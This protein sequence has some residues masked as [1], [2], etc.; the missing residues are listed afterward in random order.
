MIAVFLLAAA[1]ATKPS[2]PAVTKPST[3]KPSTKPATTRPASRPASRPAPRS[4][5]PK[6][7]KFSD[8]EHGF[9]FE[10]PYDWDRHEPKEK[11][12]KKENE[13]ELDWVVFEEPRRGPDDRFRE[14]VAVSEQ[15][16]HGE[17]EVARVSKDWE[18][19]FKKHYPDWKHVSKSDV[20]IDGAKG[21][22][23]VALFHVTDVELTGELII[24]KKGDHLIAVE[25]FTRSGLY[26]RYR[27]T[28][29]AILNSLKISE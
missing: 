27:A 8:D 29:N 11:K 2:K 7:I 6:M 23:T 9:T 22:K 10:V 18:E 25:C 5:L 16:P 26:T 20:T 14:S 21:Q 4:S 1:P 24:L 28:F 19:S 3:T 13:S 12:D 15:R 17:I